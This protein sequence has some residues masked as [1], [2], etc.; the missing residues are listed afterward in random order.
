VFDGA[1]EDA[2]VVIDEERFAAVLAHLVDNAVEAAGAA[3]HVALRQRRDGGELVIEIEDD[4]PG[5]D[6]EFVRHKLFTPF[7]STKKGG[8][9][10]GAYES[11]EFVREMGGR[12][13]VYSRPGEGTQVRIALPAVAAPVGGEAELRQVAAS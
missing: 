8:Y 7:A 10:I 13:D 5:M 11:R 12:L 4:G 1:D 3:G 9:G 2:A 6:A